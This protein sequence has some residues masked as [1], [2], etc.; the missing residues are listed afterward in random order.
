MDQIVD[1]FITVT[2]EVKVD[3]P[4]DWSEEEVIEDLKANYEKYVDECDKN[5]DVMIYDSTFVKKDDEDNT[6]SGG[7]YE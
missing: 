3:Y 7:I 5:V 6:Y 4:K 2:Y 1:A